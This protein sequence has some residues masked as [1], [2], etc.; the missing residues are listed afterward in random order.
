MNCDVL[1]VGT[2]VAGLTF[3][4]KTAI[5][6]PNLNIVIL[7]KTELQETNTTYAQGG[8]A[9]VWNLEKDSFEKHVADTH[10]AGDGLCD[11]KIVE[12]VINEGPE[13]VRE[14]IEWGTRFDKEQ[15]SNTYNLGMEGGHSDHRILHYKDYTGA[16]IQRALSEK[17]RSIANIVILEKHFA[18][19]II[20]QHHQGL[21]MHRVHPNIKCFGIYALDM[22]TGNVLKILAN[23][24]VIASGGTGQVYRS[25]TNPAIAT[26]DGIAMAYRAGARISNMEFIQF[27]PTSLYDPSNKSDR[28]FLVSEAVRGF[29]AI[30]KNEYGEEFM[31]KY[32]PRLSLA[33]RD[34]VARAIDNEMK[35]RGQENMF[36]DCRHLDHHGFLEHFPTIYEK[37]KSIGIDPFVEMIPVVP[38]QH[39][40]C[41]GIHTDEY[42][43]TN[44]ENMYAIGECTN[45]GLHGA[46][47]LA[48]NSL[49]E[50]LVFGHRACVHMLENWK[51]NSIPEIPEWNS[52]STT[53]PKELILITQSIKELK[54][55]MSQYVGIVR[56]EQR[57]KRA[58][59]RLHALYEETEEL[60]KS[61]NLSPQLCELRN[62]ITTGYLITK[63]ATMRR[64]S[65][66]LHYSTDYPGHS[67]YL[68][69]TY[70]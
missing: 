29:G 27:H 14:I 28:S 46:N 70:M 35:L 7:T 32:D 10:D 69:Y 4:I 43:Q 68:E 62:L 61:T 11:P 47:R 8:V 21:Y 64:E 23:K 67:P 3:A 33:P 34:I 66:G 49:L 30:L 41:G 59:R 13:R 18:I 38:A 17:A 37:C 56:T 36:L 16:E 44:I 57:S 25:T 50:G 54:E 63:S 60:Y 51:E 31:H 20:T 12:I 22:K 45:S 1:V 52:S 2:G 53:E 19:E 9:A 58:I 24:T 40:T 6:Q 55:L 65:R 26:G 5:A 42:G 39:Y 15:N 48:S